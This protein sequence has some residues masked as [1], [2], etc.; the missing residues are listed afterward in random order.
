MLNIN[1]KHLSRAFWSQI[2]HPV[3]LSRTRELEALRAQATYDTGTTPESSLIALASVVR[4]VKPKRVIEIGTFIG[5]STAMLAMNGAEVHTCDM[6]NNLQLP[7]WVGNVKQYHMSSTDMLTQLTGPFDLIFID[8]RLRSE[9]AAHLTRLLTPEA[10]VALD[11]FEG[12]EKGVVNAMKFDLQRRLLIYPPERAF[13]ERYAH[14]DSQLALIIP[15]L[16]LTAQ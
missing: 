13:T 7:E 11:D 12:V 4:A 6:S 3:D 2:W 14:D 5:K 8:G 15:G 10:I 9:D 16:H 1:R